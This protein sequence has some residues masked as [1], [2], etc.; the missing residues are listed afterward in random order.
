MTQT[1]AK[2]AL[3]ISKKVKH[4]YFEKNK[5]LSW[6]DKLYAPAQWLCL[7]T[8]AKDFHA[9]PAICSASWSADGIDA[10]LTYP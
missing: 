5:S 6:P 3:K 4:F 10:V 7:A 1:L 8:A 2:K 9:A